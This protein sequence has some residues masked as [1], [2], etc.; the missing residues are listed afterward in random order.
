MRLLFVG[1]KFGEVAGGVEKMCIML[2]NNMHERGHE[3][4]LL[5]WDQPQAVPFY[6]L[7][8]GVFWHKLAIGDHAE[9]ATW[10]VRWQRMLK[11]RK[12]AE[13]I[14]PDLVIAFQLGPFAAVRLYL[15]GK[16]IP[17]IAAL[18]NAPSLYD[19]TSAGKYRWLWFQVLRL[20][21]AITVQLPAYIKCYP[22]YAQKKMHVIPNP[23]T[24]PSLENIS[25]QTES[26]EHSGG[27]I[28]NVGRLCYQKNQ[29]LLIKAFALIAQRYPGWTLR[30]VGDGED[31]EQLKTLSCKLNIGSQ[32]EFVGV[33]KDVSSEYA[34]ADIFCFPSLWEGFPNALAEAMSHR[35]PVLGLSSCDGTNGLIESGV[36]GLLSGSLVE[37]LAECLLRLIDSK[38]L[39]DKFAL[40]A[41]DSLRPYAPHVVFDRWEQLFVSLGSGTLN[42]CAE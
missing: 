23:V 22:Q 8:Q 2:A 42:T 29:T 34:A 31:L 27:I 30:L 25:S 4:H 19:Y 11:V 32:I 36:N 26:L 38:S 7:N 24:M 33:K 35:L 10:K 13:L 15:Q 41:A 37:D 16:S 28:L 21:D 9:K 3:V 6:P 12:L 39:R 14:K 40:S 1:R 17:M 20:A 5:T 18:R